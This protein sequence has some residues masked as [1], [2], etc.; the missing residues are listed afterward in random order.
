MTVDGCWKPQWQG[1]V[2]V[3]IQCRCTLRTVTGPMLYIFVG[4]VLQ[5][6]FHSSNPFA[7]T[8]QSHMRA[9]AAR[10]TQMRGHTHTHTHTLTH[11]VHTR[12]THTHLEAVQGDD[13]L[14]DACISGFIRLIDH[15]VHEV[16]ARQDG[17]GQCYIVLER[18][19]LRSKCV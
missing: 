15:D 7:A 4:R 9:Q 14:R 16:E 10:I 18:L 5:R 2:S 17:G 6:P 1:L 3:S 8:S 13:V 19:G 11:K 12:Y